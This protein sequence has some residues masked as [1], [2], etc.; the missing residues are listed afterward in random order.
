MAASDSPFVALVH[1][2][3]PAFKERA[4]S[5][6]VKGEFVADNY[7]TLKARKLMSAAV[8]TE[9]GGGGASHEE[10]CE[11]LRTLAHYCPSTALAL[12]MHT[13][14]VSAA[15]WRHLHGQ[16]A[17]P[18]LQKVAEG[19]IVLVSTGAGDWLESN[20]TAVRAEGGYRV[21][22][23][24]RFGSGSPAGDMALTSAPFDDPTDG[25]VVLHFPVPLNAQ[26][27]RVGN[28]WDTLGMR[29][30][31]SHTLHF[32]NVF[33]PEG[34]VSVKRPRGKWHPSFAVIGVVALPIVVSVYIGVAE[35]AAEIARA[36]A[37]KRGADAKL[38]VL[39]GQ[40]E[41]ELLIAQMAWRGMVDAARGY[42]FE[43]ELPLANGTFMRKTIAAN[44]VRSCLN[45]AVEIVGGGAFYRSNPLER[46]WRDAQGV[47]FH[48]IQEMAQLEF[49]GRI[50]LGLPPVA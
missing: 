40:L 50:A 13:H 16:P 45:K 3:G 41:N 17:A 2:I 6:D 22:A 42:A 27:V 26:G 20:G 47:Q 24:K 18:L 38:I 36:A 43:P 46:L 5:A 48:P 34:A 37:R 25:P 39:L 31:G 30:T 4:A 29:A 23:Q 44:H 7:K 8:P 33:V 12:S 11:L 35:A 32:D 28:D 21:T 15:V 9:L 14:L 19:Q 49:T 10:L 1:D